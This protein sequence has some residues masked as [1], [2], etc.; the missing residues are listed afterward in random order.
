MGLMA[1]N[2]ERAL[3]MTKAP[4]FTRQHAA[5][6][7]QRGFKAL[8]AR[9]LQE[10]SGCA[11]LVLKYMPELAEAHFLVGLIALDTSDWAAARKAF[12]SVVNVDKTH[13]AAWAQLARVLVMTGD[14]NGA[15][16]A[17]AKAVKLGSDDPL[18]LD[19]IGTVYTL[20]GDQDAALEYFDRACA[21][22]D[23]PVFH[24]NRAKC[25]VFHGDFNIARDALEKVLS[26]QPQ[27]TQAHWILSRLQKATD[28]DHVNNMLDLVEKFQKD[29]P[30]TAYLYYGLGKEYEDMEMW[31]E[32]FQAYQS[33]GRVRRAQVNY[34]EADEIETF[35]AFEETFTQEWLANAGDGYDTQSPIFIIGQP[36][37]GTTLVER[38]ITA[39]DDVFSAGELQ[40]FGMAVKRMSGAASSG[41]IS[42]DAVRA[43]G[44]IDLAELGQAYMDTTRVRRSNLAHFVDKLPVN[45]LYTPLI[46]AALPGAKIIHVTRDA[47]DSCF[48][49]FK[50]FFADAYFHSYDQGEMAR[51][52]VRYRKLMDHYRSVLGDRMIDVA[53]EDVVADTEGQA[54]RLIDFLELS[55]QDA[56]LEFHK[57]KT[58]VT[59]AS[60]AQVREKAHS[61]SVGKWR[62][63][64]NELAPMTKILSRAGMLNI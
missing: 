28:L 63:F 1:I 62:R 38:I 43:A 60:A 13:A 11:Q 35:K 9:D 29:S 5:K 57:Q 33:G 52:H 39:R 58:A 41:M 56:S 7:L 47:M 27:N 37:T 55:W 23:S 12:S 10:A 16:K 31:P 4:A 44:G 54:R 24:L 49:S 51:H 64:E 3:D 21:G 42:A 30:P 40:Q 18:V 50:Q 59:T 46:A 34:S 25:L 8:L 22:A 15:D 2:I 6:Y 36:R 26:L 61:R 48:S 32:A 53:Y 20:I 14:Y 17:L 19:V 45:Y